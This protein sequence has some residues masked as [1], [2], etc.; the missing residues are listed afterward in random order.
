LFKVVGTSPK[1]LKKVSEK[2]ETVPEKAK[3]QMDKK[4]LPTTKLSKFRGS[5]DHAD[6]STSAK[7]KFKKSVSS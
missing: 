6:I 7:K 3:Y 5:V 1:V 2:V 4:L